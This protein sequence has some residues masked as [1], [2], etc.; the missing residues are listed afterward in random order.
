MAEAQQIRNVYDRYIELANA[1]D[2]EGMVV[3]YEEGAVLDCGDGNLRQGREAI[4]RTRI[5]RPTLCCRM[6]APGR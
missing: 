4:A 3:L 1:G 5:R 6:A 2:V